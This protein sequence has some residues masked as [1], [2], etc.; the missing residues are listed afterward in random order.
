MTSEI[1]DLLPGLRIV[2]RDDA[3]VACCGQV[4]AHGTELDAAHGLYEP[5]ET[6]CE[7]RGAI[8]EDVDTPILV[9]GRGHGA[10]SR[11]IHTHSEGTL[12]LVLRELVRRAVF[13]C[14]VGVVHIYAA[15]VG[16][17]GEVL[18]VLTQS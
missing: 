16:R 12:G 1:G 8:V 4:L 14:F 10:I 2:E 13:S 9:S 6:V 17:A 3:C 18:S 7:A 5:G 15:I 11:D